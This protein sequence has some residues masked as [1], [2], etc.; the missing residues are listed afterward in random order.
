MQILTPQTAGAPAS[1][2][3][4][5]NANTLNDILAWALPE[6]GWTLTVDDRAGNRIAATSADGVTYAFFNQYQMAELAGSQWGDSYNTAAV[7]RMYTGFTDFASPGVAAPFATGQYRGTY[8]DTVLGYAY[9][10]A[11]GSNY[12]I[13][14]DNK[15]VW[16]FTQ[17]W[18]TNHNG[19]NNSTAE[20]R[21]YV[22]YFGRVEGINPGTYNYVM[23]GAPRGGPD[24][25]HHTGMSYQGPFYAVFDAAQTVAGD[26]VYIWNGTQRGLDGWL[27]RQGAE[28]DA[29]GNRYL[30]RIY[31]SHGAVDAN[32]AYFL[33]GGYTSVGSW[34]DFFVNNHRA[35]MPAVE[36]DVGARVLRPWQ[37]EYLTNT[38][39]SNAAYGHVVL[40]DEMGPWV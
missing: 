38:N 20:H 29:L 12:H 22:Y 25:S 14:G 5:R 9:G 18:G 40:M 1:Q 37:T 28:F 36:V 23:M 31:L 15:S 35:T 30:S 26:Q 10:N 24:S 6:L 21:W 33:R 2:L 11:L 39:G 13:Y 3:H 27:G 19:M 8:I 32:P 17:C 7:A 34:G 16:L 4:L